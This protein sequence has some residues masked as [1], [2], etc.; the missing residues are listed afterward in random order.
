MRHFDKKRL[1]Y[2]SNS[3]VL[4]VACG[5]GVFGQKLIKENS[6]T[7]FVV[8]CAQIALDTSKATPHKALANR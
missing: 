6:C 4:D 3:T 7:V 8:D 5:Y 1:N 2:I